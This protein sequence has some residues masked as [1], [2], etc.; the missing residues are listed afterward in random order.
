LIGTVPVPSIT[1]PVFPGVA[2]A[3]PAAATTRPGELRFELLRAYPA[4]LESRQRLAMRLVLGVSAGSEGALYPL[5]AGLLDEEDVP[6][7]SDALA[8]MGRSMSR[9]PDDA[10][11]QLVETEFHAGTVRMGVLRM[12]S[13]SFAYVQVAQSDLAR[14]GLKQVW[15]L[16]AMYLQARDIAALERSVMQASAKIR[17]IRG[18]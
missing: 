5:G 2:R 13:D 14:F 8:R 15:E 4:G 9:A 16:P 12:G 3:S 11:L 18:R 1:A 10:S 7:L 6:V 17:A